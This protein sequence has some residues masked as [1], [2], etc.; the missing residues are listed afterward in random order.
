MPGVG[1]V[2]ERYQPYSVEIIEVT[3]GRFWKPYGKAV[4]AMIKAQP[5]PRGGSTPAGNPDMYQQRAHRPHQS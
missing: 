2:D 3:G 5:D 1:S 4:D